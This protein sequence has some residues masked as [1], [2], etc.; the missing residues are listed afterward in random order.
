MFF[1]PLPPS[2]G[3]RRLRLVDGEL[4][5]SGSVELHVEGLWG[6]VASEPAVRPELATRICQQLGCG[7]AI[8]SHGH[9]HGR[10]AEPGSHLPVRWEVVEPCEGGLLFDCFNRTSARQGRAP[11]FITCSGESSPRRRPG[12]FA[13]PFACPA[14]EVGEP[15][16]GDAGQLKPPERGSS[17]L[18]ACPAHP[19]HP[20]P[21]FL[22]R[23][24]RQNRK[25][26][27]RARFPAAAL[28]APPPR[29]R[30]RCP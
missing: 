26:P 29:T 12:S 16:E 7:S 13:G 24:R 19:A 30:R 25:S 2:P 27:R 3:P 6:A 5:C 23:V 15:L 11:A 22:S 14:E 1:L 10:L 17:P 4:G 21:L 9:G 18:P 20:L 28:P 8:E